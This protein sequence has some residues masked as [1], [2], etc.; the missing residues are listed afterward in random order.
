MS[1][2][3]LGLKPSPAAAPADAGAPALPG[4][5]LGVLPPPLY[6]LRD[7]RDACRYLSTSLF[8]LCTTTSLV[9]TLFATCP[10]LGG[11]SDALGW[12]LWWAAAAA[13]LALSAAM[14]YRIVLL[15]KSGMHELAVNRDPDFFFSGLIPIAMALLVSGAARYTELYFGEIGVIVSL[16]FFWIAWSF[17]LAFMVFVTFHLAQF[18]TAELKDTLPFWV[19]T[20]MPGAAAASA[21]GKVA[22]LCGIHGMFAEGRHVLY[23]SLLLTT[24]TVLQCFF[25][26]FILFQKTVLSG[27][28][29]SRVVLSALFPNAPIA[30]LGGAFLEIGVALPIIFQRIQDTGQGSVS[31]DQVGGLASG[32]S[33]GIGALAPPSSSGAFLVLDEVRIAL[34]DHG[35]TSLDGFTS[36]ESS[37]FLAAADGSGNDLF[38]LSPDLLALAL[39]SPS[40]AAAFVLLGLLAFGCIL[41]WM[42]MALGAIGSVILQAVACS[43]R[44]DGSGDAGA[45]K[46]GATASRGGGSATAMQAL[47]LGTVLKAEGRSDS[48]ARRV[49]LDRLERG[50]ATAG[51]TGSLDSVSSAPGNDRGGLRSRGAPAPASPPAPA[52]P[53]A[54]RRRSF[55]LP[56]FPSYTPAW[57]GPVFPVGLSAA[58]AFRLGEILDV[59]AFGVVGCVVGFC[60]TCAWAVVVTVCLIDMY[61]GKMFVR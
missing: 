7:R 51:G 48:A 22:A 1:T 29:P 19:L 35:L 56:S 18:S 27:F 23:A 42:P 45:A 43:D 40:M 4:R 28:P 33:F 6:L 8:N 58:L 17:A 57:W 53:S 13:F 54:P 49:E 12:A 5:L 10:F 52:R 24:M 55:A 26:L 44:G 46:G 36:S 3:E 32:S 47:E 34:D 50:D 9:G 39:G 21:G 11:W 14:A 15:G 31:S 38:A 20:V 16:P 59:T 2:G 41:W 25:V 37:S 60:C 61:S 30:I